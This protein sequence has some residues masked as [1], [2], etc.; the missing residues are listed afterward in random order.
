MN[1]NKIAERVFDELNRI[2]NNLSENI[3]FEEHFDI[4]HEFGGINGD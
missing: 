2:L 3:N 4:K 1:A